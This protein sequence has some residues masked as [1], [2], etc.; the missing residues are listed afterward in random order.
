[1]ADACPNWGDKAPQGKLPMVL[2]TWP[3]WDQDEEQLETRISGT[4]VD[5]EV[6]LET[7][8]EGETDE[9]PE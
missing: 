4:E 2:G 7:K 1:M 9:P 5:A 6:E 8:T 3:L